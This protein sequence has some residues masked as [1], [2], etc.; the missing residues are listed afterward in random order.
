MDFLSAFLIF[1]CYINEGRRHKK[2]IEDF[3]MEKENLKLFSLQVSLW[4]MLAHVDTD[5]YICICTHIHTYI[6][7][8]THA[9]PDPQLMETS[10]YLYQ[11]DLSQD[12]YMSGK[13]IYNAT[14]INN[15][16]EIILSYFCIKI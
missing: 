3:I 8:C 13:G 9:V 15:R 5:A 4:Y 16:S 11:L 6:H 14:R 12:E 2:G 1:A 10:Y 7:T